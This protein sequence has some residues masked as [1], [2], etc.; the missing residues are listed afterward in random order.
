MNT[1]ERKK[2]LG[3]CPMNE[4]ATVNRIEKTKNWAAYLGKLEENCAPSWG[5]VDHLTGTTAIQE[6]LEPPRNKA[7]AAMTIPN[8]SQ[9]AH[10]SSFD[11]SSRQPGRGGAISC[12]F[13]EGP[14]S[15]VFIEQSP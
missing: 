15:E 8:P 14:G 10:Q 4:V 1:N 13:T 5:R 9:T 11:Q 7:V 2:S 3:R 12:S 6:K